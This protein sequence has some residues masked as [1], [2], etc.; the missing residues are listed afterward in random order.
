MK[1]WVDADAAPRMIKELL[2]KVS[3]RTGVSITFVANQYLFLP[4]DHNIG[5][6]QVGAGMD[7]ADQKIVELCT[8]DDLVI[9]ADIPLASAAVKK[10]AFALN[11]R[12]KLYDAT[13]IGDIL[14]VRDLMEH[15][16]G[17]IMKEHT[18]GPDGFTAKDCERFANSLD[19]FMAQKR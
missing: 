18:G 9:T 1:I 7:V 11:P 2:F 6:I 3:R 15:I 16:R 17:D 13:N 19:K 4:K 5:F 14:A 12:G 10:G 8:K